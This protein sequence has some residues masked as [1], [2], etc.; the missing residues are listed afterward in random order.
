MRSRLSGKI[1]FSIGVL[2]LLILLAWALWPAPRR[3]FAKYVCSPIPNSVRVTFF[4]SD[5]WLGINPEPVSY[6]IF[7]AS[8]AD[9]AAVIQQGGFTPASTNTHV[10]IPSGPP[11][12]LT[13][14]QL[15]ASGRIYTRTHNA[16]GERQRIPHGHNRTWSE[17]LWI[18]ATGTN[19][20][21]LIWGI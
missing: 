15:Q 12:W 4:Q 19:A 10:P 14:D 3:S 16:T 18:D 2:V 6:L 9:V 17:Y 21:F 20:Y 7:S 1:I 11:A 13:P 5:D 8:A